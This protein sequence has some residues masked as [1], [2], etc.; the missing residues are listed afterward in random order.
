MPWCDRPGGDG[1][2]VGGTGGMERTI[3]QPWWAARSAGAWGAPAGSWAGLTDRQLV[4]IALRGDP[5]AYGELVR[6]H[7]AAVYNVAY[8]LVG[9]RQEALDL[10]QEAFVRAYH[11]LA[12]F[13]QHRPFGPWI[14]R[15]AANVALSWLQRRR[16]PT[17]PLTGHPAH[18]G[19]TAAEAAGRPPPDYSAEP[20]RIYL[21]VERQARVRAA[22][23]ALPPHYRAVIELRHFQ[24][25]TYEEIA[26]TLAIPVSDVKSHLFRARRLL[27]QSLEA[28]T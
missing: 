9:D 19:G 25:L 22:I 26:A 10:A 14:K 27:R 1:D 21:A 11:A 28:R 13:D 8:R 5:E 18:A 15:I 6:R 24:D 12:S 4:A 2:A 23:L 17:V 16:V 3:A 7:Q 20:E